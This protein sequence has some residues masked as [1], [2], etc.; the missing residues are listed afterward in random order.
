MAGSGQMGRD[1]VD[2]RFGPTLGVGMLGGARP[3]GSATGPERSAVLHEIE[4]DDDAD[5]AANWCSVSAPGDSQ[6]VSDGLAQHLIYA[7]D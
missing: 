3:Y 6:S 5:M 1:E 4:H 7:R 2:G